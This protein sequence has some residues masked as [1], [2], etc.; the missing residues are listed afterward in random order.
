MLVVDADRE[1]R[2]SLC[3]LLERGGHRPLSAAGV[4]EAVRVF[5]ARHPEL[6][7]LD[8][9][10]GEDDGFDVLGRIREVSD[11]VPVMAI[12]DEAGELEIVRAL[13]EGA[14][15]FVSRPFRGAEVMA[16]AAALIRRSRGTQA[17]EI[18]DDGCVRIDF[19]GASVT[20]GGEPVQLTPQEFRLLATFVRHPGQVLSADQLLR[21]AWRGDRIGSTGEEVRVYIGYLRRKLGAVLEHVPIETV[22]GFGY[23]YDP[24]SVAARREHVR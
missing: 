8:L 24:A 13:G 22:R 6:V 1:S 18:L 3:A 12:A 4:R 5:F 21:L 23:R 10:L 15:D 7:I 9:D 20:V 14:D 19:V 2:E 11:D 17:Q 16:R